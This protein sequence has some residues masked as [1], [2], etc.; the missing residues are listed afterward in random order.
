MQGLTRRALGLAGMGA[1]LAGCDAGRPAGA[2]GSRAAL[3][4]AGPMGDPGKLR[5]K[6]VASVDLRNQGDAFS[7]S[8]SEMAWS[9]D[10]SRLVAVNG[11]GNFLNVIDTSSWRV[12]VRFRIMSVDGQR[13]F[14]FASGG[15]DLIASKRVDP[16]GTEN[17]PAFSVFEPDTGRVLRESQLLPVFLPALNGRPND[18]SLQQRREG[19]QLTVSPD[20]RFVFLMFSGV[21]AGT[22]RRF[23]YHL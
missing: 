12:L 20:G 5:L 2:A 22:R 6:Q 10:G 15:R 23:A 9:P 17:P 16:G 14:G 8:V 4:G 7:W 19:Q 21:V 18:L 1:A 3:L 13:P 11:L